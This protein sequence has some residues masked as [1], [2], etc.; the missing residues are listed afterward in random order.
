MGARVEDHGGDRLPLTM[1]GGGLRGIEYSSPV[2][3][4]Q[5]KSAIMLAGLTGRVEVTVTEPAR[6]RDH[7]ERMLRFLG[8]S[9][10]VRG[11]SVTLDGASFIPDHVPPIEL[12]I[13]GDPSSAAFLVGAALLAE[14]GELRL[15]HVGVNPTRT[16]FLGVLSRMGAVVEQEA[17]RESG[18]EPVADLVVRPSTLR[19]TDVPA[20]EVPSLI[21][22]VPILAVLASRSS[23]QTRFHSVGE[24]RVKESDRLSLLAANLRA[25]GAQASVDGD[26]LVVEG[27]GAPARGRVETAGDHRI[28]M[29]FGVLG[30]VPEA[31]VRLSE[32]ASVDV[33]YPAFFGDLER[34]RAS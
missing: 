5:I 17:S 9:V 3:S 27:G 12:D 1:H 4:A 7:T 15:E 31:D 32:A 30:T 33:S 2:A 14:G 24:L 11:T 8:V 18:G 25:I 6:S 28:A 19:G 21:D 29:A 23:G 10:E 34:I 13:P 26:D 20:S 22:E 16:G